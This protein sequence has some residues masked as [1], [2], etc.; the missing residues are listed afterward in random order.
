MC[1]TPIFCPGTKL[2]MET[3]GGFSQTTHGED[4]KRN[5]L[6]DEWISDTLKS[7]LIK[8]RPYWREKQTAILFKQLL[9][10]RFLKSNQPVS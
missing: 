1:L 9:C 3:K 2:D 4:C 6:E 5:K 8:L 7:P 10:W